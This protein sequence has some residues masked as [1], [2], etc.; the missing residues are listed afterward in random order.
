M[1][2]NQDTPISLLDPHPSPLS[3]S[4]I[5]VFVQSGQT[6]N[7]DLDELKTFI[8]SGIPVGTGDITGSGTSGKI[9]LFNAAKNIVNSRITQTL[10]TINIPSPNG[11]AYLKVED[12]AISMEVLNAFYH[13]VY[14][15][16]TKVGLAYY[17]GVS[18]GG[19]FES[20]ITHS[21]VYHDSR[22]TISAPNIQFPT[23]TGNTVPYLDTNQYM[24]SSGV[25]LAKL[26]T[27]STARSDLQVQIDAVTSGLSWKQEVMC[28]TT[29]NITL[30]GLQTIDGYTTLA[31]DRVLV[32]DQ[33][34]ASQNCIY[35]AKTGSWVRATDCDSTS[36]IVSAT[37]QVRFGTTN[38]D[39][40]WS[41]SNT[42]QPVI[43]TDSITFV[44]INGGATYTNGSGLT[45]SGNVFSI[46]AGQ[47][48]NSMI[49]NNSIDLTAKVTNALKY[50]NGGTQS[51]TV[52][53]PGALP[54]ATLAGYAYDAAN[55][56]YE[57]TTKTLNVNNIFVS[58]DDGITGVNIEGASNLLR[59]VTTDAGYDAAIIQAL[60][61][62]LK[63]D[64]ASGTAG[65]FTSSENPGEFN[66]TGVL[67]ADVDYEGV[68]INRQFTRPASGG[69][70]TAK[71][72]GPLLFVND[73]TGALGT[74]DL[75][76]FQKQGTKRFRVNN[77][78][79]IVY[80]PGSEAANSYLVDDGTGAGIAV[81][82]RISTFGLPSVTYANTTTT[83]TDTNIITCVIPANTLTAN[84]DKVVYDFVIGNTGGIS[85]DVTY[86]VK[87]NA[88][89]L[90]NDKTVTLNANSDPITLRVT[91][92]R[93]T[94]STFRYT[95]QYNFSTHTTSLRTVEYNTITGFDFT[96]ASTLYIVGNQL[97][98]TRGII[99]VEGHGVY[100]KAS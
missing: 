77:D 66:Q 95:L 27:I 65:R 60:G 92:E 43:G 62:G 90:L 88:T 86:K 37:V 10:T 67:S 97:S 56:N 18:V 45:L 70:S 64:S 73:S 89:S 24:R 34:T 68:V 63:V 39:T 82:S 46:G 2:T 50:I 33:S 53:L 11:S 93:L 94:S 84:T 78:G 54:Y 59:L 75:A 71:A 26:N 38:K 12:D 35:I 91:I 87:I 20:T 7:G 16:E 98:T 69:G 74:G 72:T 83:N 81:W 51:S 42:N 8:T 96:T 85:G 19:G 31:E 15:D 4:E 79:K 44:Q 99:G 32:K 52:P 49:A 36:E 9:P 57:P 5:F 40:Q 58:P 23:L 6:V 1:A 14:I 17:D 100:Y 3:G 21:I 61:N 13:R 80:T 29:A 25:T 48:V 28:A 41:C 30:S 76:C 47:V 55:Y 22:I